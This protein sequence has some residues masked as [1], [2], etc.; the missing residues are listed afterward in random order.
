MLIDCQRVWV[1]LIATLIGY[2]TATQ[3]LKA[4]GTRAEEESVPR[5]GRRG[6]SIHGWFKRLSDLPV[7]LKQIS[8]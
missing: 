4:Q 1:G 3:M 8:I 7:F 6:P 5:H 2:L